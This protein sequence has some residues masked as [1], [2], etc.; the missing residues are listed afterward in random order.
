M[1]THAT[2]NLNPRAVSIDT[3]LH[4]F[5]PVKHVDHMHPNAVIAVAA[6]GELQKLDEGDLTATRWLY[7][8]WLRP[9]FE[10]GL[11]MQEIVRRTTR[12]ARRS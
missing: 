1:Y 6:A 3:P 10:L 8:P 5:I 2:F 7:M 11:R 4:G 9:G 12:R